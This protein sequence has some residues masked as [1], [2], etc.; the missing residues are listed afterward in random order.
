M[1][2][3][4]SGAI[5]LRWLNEHLGEVIGV[6]TEQPEA[7]CAVRRTA[8]DLGVPVWSRSRAH[9][10]INEG[11]IA[12]DLGISFL[13]PH[14]IVQPLLGFPKL[15]IVNFHPAPLPDFKGTGGYNVAILDRLPKWAVSAHFV[16]AD[17][18]TGP[19][20]ECLEFPIDADTIT[21]R[22]LERQSQIFLLDLFKRTISR[23]ARGETIDTTPNRGGRYISRV[24]MESM[25][26]VTGGDDVDRKV[27]AFWFPPYVGAYVEI[28]GARF[29]LVSEDILEEIA[30]SMSTA[31]LDQ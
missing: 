17:I 8:A 24:E 20:I 14:K 23:F 30:D 3:K 4:D 22:S 26:R 28:D 16:D 1:G 13:H 12:C 10:L 31:D 11:E 6:V 7:S 21:A 15:G 29:T 5:A 19:I 18:D 25:K 27:R 9:A 2:R